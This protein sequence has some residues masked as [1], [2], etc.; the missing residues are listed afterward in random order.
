MSGN[1]CLCY[2]QS[3][4]KNYLVMINEQSAEIKG[5]MISNVYD[6]VN[7]ILISLNFP[8]SGKKTLKIITFA[9]ELINFFYVFR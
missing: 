9:L 2:F 5:E 8:V 7:A 6:A 3:S 1:C 4:Y